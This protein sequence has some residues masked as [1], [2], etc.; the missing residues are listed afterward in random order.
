MNLIQQF[1]QNQIEKLTKDNHIPSFKSG[2]TVKVNLRIIEGNNERIQSYQGTVIARNNRSIC[3]S[4]I[5][6]KISH[7]EAVERKFML[8]SPMISS[9][10]VVKYGIVNRAKLYFLRKLQGRKA[11]IKEKIFFKERK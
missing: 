9:I 7:G 11:K 10:E 8:Y 4:F 3:S 6:R 2:D 1:E 5:V